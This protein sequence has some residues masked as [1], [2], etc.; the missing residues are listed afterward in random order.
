MDTNIFCRVF[1]K[2][3]FL[4][5]FIFVGVGQTPVVAPDVAVNDIHKFK[6]TT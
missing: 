5:N 6:Y 2:V 3:G 1:K 4:K